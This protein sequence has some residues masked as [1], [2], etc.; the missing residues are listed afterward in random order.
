[1]KVKIINSEGR[2][3]IHFPTSKHDKYINLGELIGFKI[4]FDS[5]STGLTVDY[6]FEINDG[7]NVKTLELGEYTFYITEIFIEY[8]EVSYEE[9][10]RSYEFKKIIETFFKTLKEK[11]TK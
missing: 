6:D 7:F 1:M 10:L 5:F 9:V 3:S 8:Y 11:K 2:S 4:K